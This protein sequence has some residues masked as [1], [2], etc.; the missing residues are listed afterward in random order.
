M[1][2]VFSVVYCFLLRAN[3]LVPIAVLAASLLAYLNYLY[4]VRPVDF[5]YPSIAVFL[6]VIF[7]FVDLLRR[8]HDGAK[9]HVGTALASS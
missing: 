2:D 3:V 9:P 6:V 5:I 8:S 4:G 7:L 1:A